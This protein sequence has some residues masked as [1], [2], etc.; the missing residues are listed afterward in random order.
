MPASPFN[1]SFY[2]PVFAPL[3]AGDRCRALDAGTPDRSIHAAL[4]GATLEAAFAHARIVEPDM[5]RACLAAVWLLHDELDESHVISQS[6][7]APTG[8]FWHGVMHRREG[9]FANAKYWFAR[10]GRHEALPLIGARIQELASTRRVGARTH[11]PGSNP[12]AAPPIEMDS[13]KVGAKAPTL[14][15]AEPDES[16]QPFLHRIAPAGVYDPRAMTDACQTALRTG[17]NEAHRNFCQRAQQAEWEALFD[18][19]YRQAIDA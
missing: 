12:S 5:A 8:S 7:D 6:I 19:C 9:D 10:I 1:P 2:G 13:L 3:L 18:Y 16:L 4:A 14:R 15:D 17:A 11:L